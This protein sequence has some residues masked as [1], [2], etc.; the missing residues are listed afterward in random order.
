MPYTLCPPEH[1]M[2]LRKAIHQ[3]RSICCGNAPRHSQLRVSLGGG[4][5]YNLKFE[6]KE[7]GMTDCIRVWIRRLQL[8]SFLKLVKFTLSSYQGTNTYGFYQ[9][10]NKVSTYCQ[11]SSLLK[12]ALKISLILPLS[13]NIPSPESPFSPLSPLS[14]DR[15]SWRWARVSAKLA[16][17]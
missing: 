8:H 13:D 11:Q 12:V 14:S 9:T 15:F 4:N 5:R 2:L 6:I 1:L 17:K 7:L 10:H 16:R 3:N